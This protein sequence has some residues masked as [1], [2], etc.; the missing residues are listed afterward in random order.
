MVVLQDILYNT[1]P[2]VVPIKNALLCLHKGERVDPTHQVTL[3]ERHVLRLLEFLTSGSNEL[4]GLPA[5]HQRFPNKPKEHRQSIPRIK[6]T[7][8]HIHAQI[9]STSTLT[10]FSTLRGRS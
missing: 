2:P 6:D 1:A 7:L 5:I 8:N 10:R 4:K 9:S 3:G